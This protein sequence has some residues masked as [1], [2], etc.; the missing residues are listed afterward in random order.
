VAKR[1]G[2]DLHNIENFDLDI[3]KVEFASCGTK[4]SGLLMIPR[5]VAGPLPAIAM[6]PGLSGVKEGSIA[7][8]ADFFARGGFVVLAFDNINFGESGGEPRQEADPM[9]Q[10]RGYR[11]AI[12]FLCLQPEV[13]RERIGIWGTS[14]AG[15]H[16]LEIAAHD[17]RVRCV[18]SQIG[19]ISGFEALR[20]AFRPA[21]RQEILRETNQDRERRFEGHPP[22]MIKAVSNDPAEP[23]AMPGPAAYEYFMEQA[24]VAPSWQ[25]RLTLRSLD[26]LWGLEN[27]VFMPRITPTPLLMIVALEDELVPSDLSLAAYAQAHEPKKLVL[28]PGNHFTPYV[29]QFELTGNQAR[30]WFTR[31]LIVGG[32]VGLN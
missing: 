17:R 19:A 7:K 25:N 6:A 12:T 9:L 8:Y 15:G 31:H 1:T 20:R 4:L 11:D 26:L 18:V 14:Y 32:S 13:D 21:A 10:R 28:L 23:C 24:K 2:N 22:R 30:D 3:R 27:S 5:R 29:E 16:V